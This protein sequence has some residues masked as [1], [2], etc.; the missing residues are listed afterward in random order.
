MSLRRSNTQMSEQ[1]TKFAERIGEVILKTVELA[2][3]MSRLQDEAT[4]KSPPEAEAKPSPKSKKRKTSKD[5]SAV[6]PNQAEPSRVAAPPAK[7]YT[8][9]SS[10][11]GESDT[12]G[13]MPVVSDDLVSS[14]HE[15][16]TS[17]VTSTDEDDFQPFALP[18][19]VDEPANG[20]FVGDLPLV[21][22]PAPI[23]L[24]AYPVLD[25]LLDADADDDV[26]L[27]DDEPLEDDVEGE[28]LIADGEGDH[29]VADAQADA[30]LIAD[31]PVDPLVAPLLD[32][33]PVQFDRALFEAHADPR[34]AHTLNGW[35]DADDELPPIP[36]H[37]TDARHMD[38]PFSFAQYTPP[39]RP[40]E[41]SST[42]PFGH[43]P[44]S[45]PVI[46][47]FPSAI[48]PVPPFS[49]PPFDPASEPFLWTSPPVM[50]PS[51]PYHPFH[52][53]YSI[54]DVLMSFV[55]QQEALTLRIQEL[56]RAQ[57]PPCQCHGQTHPASSQPPRPLLPD[58]AAR[59]WVLGFAGLFSVDCLKDFG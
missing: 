47:Q 55:V 44:T 49:V 16:H 36:P 35:I 58:S 28:A 43:V 3:A 51:D 37:T 19:A 46:P 7:K 29:A 40:G 20:P 30:P 50:P 38:F 2:I 57:P 1:A 22:I 15:I 53:G 12:T 24:A 13:P 42:H 14:E 18:D 25:I 45:V 52:M 54:E 59:L 9:D 27:F 34:D 41:G 8:M 26:D 23:P 17:D 39:A 6:A 4:Q 11:T 56:E 32:P 33:A 48:P 5:P 10:G 31:V 21:E